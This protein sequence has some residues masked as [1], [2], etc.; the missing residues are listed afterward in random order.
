MKNLLI[1]FIVQLSISCIHNSK[2][3]SVTKKTSPVSKQIKQLR[4]DDN[5]G[6]HSKTN[7]EIYNLLIYPK[8]DFKDTLNALEFEITCQRDTDGFYKKG[9]CWF[10][11]VKNFQETEINWKT[12][13]SWSNGFKYDMTAL[14]EIYFTNEK[15]SFP[16]EKSRT[17]II[18]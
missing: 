4:K 12:F 8:V 7:K 13:Y 2:E 11:A 17:K 1:L 5:Y 15:L 3:N 6:F 16:N 10:V 18:L 9:I 14:N